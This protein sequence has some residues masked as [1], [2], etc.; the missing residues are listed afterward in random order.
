MV[1]LPESFPPLVTQDIHKTNSYIKP[2]ERLMLSSKKISFLG[3]Q[4]EITMNVISLH[5]KGKVIHNI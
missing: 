3:E 2:L 1:F 4:A 5:F